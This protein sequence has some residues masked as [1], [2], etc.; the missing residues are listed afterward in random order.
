MKRGEKG[1]K[2]GGGEGEMSFGHERCSC[3]IYTKVESNLNY[4]D[5]Q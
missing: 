3:I 5:I 4:N 1:R 2:G